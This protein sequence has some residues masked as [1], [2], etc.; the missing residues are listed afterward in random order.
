ML[1]HNSFRRGNFVRVIDI[2]NYIE[3]YISEVNLFNTKLITE[4]REVVI[5]PNNLLL[6]RPTIINP[7]NKWQVIGKFSDKIRPIPPENEQ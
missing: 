6:T 7:R 2:D 5:F 3:G 4:D 1:F